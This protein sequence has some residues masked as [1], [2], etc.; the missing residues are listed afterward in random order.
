[1][2]W[3]SLS[4]LAGILLGVGGQLLLKS[5]ASGESIAAQYTAP[6]SLLGLA[7]YFVA[8]LCYM[9][10]LRE[11]PV[12]VAFPSVSLSYVLVVALAY[13]RYD[14]PL[15]WSKLAGVLFICF[16][17]FLVARQA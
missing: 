8:A 14:E 17:V 10:S 16:G 15:T 2:I 6:A 4:L 9:F 1:M 12:S 5:G 11:I 3:A 13:W 7:C